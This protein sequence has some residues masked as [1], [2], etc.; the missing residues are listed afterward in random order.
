[1]LTLMILIAIGAIVA[2]FVLRAGENR[3]F[4]TSADPHR[5]VM[6]AVGV[7]GS[8]RHWQTLHQSEHGVQFQYQ[9]RPSVIVAVILLLF[10]LI[11]GIVYVLLAGKRESLVVGIDLATNG[12]TVVQVTSNGFRGKN[13]GR[14]LERQVGL[15]AGTVATGQGAAAV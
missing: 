3:R 1:M 4:E 6:A 12:I 10:F 9:R 14:A 2:F 7:V 8:R 11:P 13:A 5:V 15:P